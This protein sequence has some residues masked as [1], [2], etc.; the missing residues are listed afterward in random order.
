MFLC[1]TVRAQIVVKKIDKITEQSAVKPEPYDSLKKIS[2]SEDFKENFK[3]VGQKLYLH[4]SRRFPARMLCTKASKIPATYKLPNDINAYSSSAKNVFIQFTKDIQNVTTCVYK[5]VCSHVEVTN[6]KAYAEVVSDSAKTVGKY[7]TIT[8]LYNRT[9]SDSISTKMR[10]ALSAIN[11]KE[12]TDGRNTTIFSDNY[13]PSNFYGGVGYIL[14][15]NE[16]GD[17]IFVDNLGEPFVSVA[18][19]TKQQ[20]LF[21]GKKFLILLPDYEDSVT[22]DDFRTSKQI[23]LRK[24][25]EFTCEVALLEGIAGISYIFTNKRGH[26]LMTDELARGYPED[27]FRLELI[28]TD[29]SQKAIKTIRVIPKTNYLR[30]VAEAKLAR[31]QALALKQQREAKAVL[32]AQNR[33][34]KHLQECTAKFG[35]EL[36]GLVAKGIVRIGMT[37]E[38][39]L[40]SWGIPYDKSKRVT[41]DEVYELFYYSYK[42]NLHFINDKLVQIEQ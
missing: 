40:Y 33:A 26:T 13:E 36:G 8:D 29:R 27:E 3:F 28:G 10:R 41:A 11:A 23:A 4:T 18:Y 32:D 16:D 35:D 22:V 38:M 39:C 5:P 30:K 34:K 15:K 7:Y 9:K 24:H 19:F 25:D 1:S 37:K 21:N 42:R 12:N 2:I 17:S 14:L 20:Q 31:T 6:S